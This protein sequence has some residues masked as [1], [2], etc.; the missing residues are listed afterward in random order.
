MVDLMASRGHRHFLGGSRSCLNEKQGGGGVWSRALQSHL[1]G[2]R[3]CLGLIW[4][5]AQESCQQHFN[6]QW[7]L[8]TPVQVS[9]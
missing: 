9:P 6:Q 5:E 1:R 8:G 3:R 2:S 4:P 7:F